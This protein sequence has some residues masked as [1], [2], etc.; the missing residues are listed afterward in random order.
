M[1]AQRYLLIVLA[2]LVARMAGAQTTGPFSPTEWPATRDAAKT[3][4]YYVTDDALAPPSGTWVPTLSILSGGDQETVD[5]SIGGFNGKKVTG[6]FMNVADTGFDEWADDEFIDILV[7]A[8]GDAGLFNAQGN[9]RNFN[10]LTGVLPDLA[11][12]VGGQVPVEA[13]NKKWN[14]ILFRIPNGLRPDGTRFVGSVPEGASAPAGGVNGGTIRFEGVPNLIVRAVAFGPEGSFGTPEDINK[15]APGDVC[16]PEP[17][18]NLVG[19]DISANT[20]SHV[21]VIN[22]GDQLVS[23]VDGVGPAG[24]KR[25]A[26]VPSG[27][28]LNFGVTENYLGKACNDPRALKVCVEFYDDPAFAGAS[29]TFGPEAYATDDKSGIAIF[30]VAQRQALQGTGTWIRRSWVVPAA[31]LRGVNAGSLTAGPR[32]ASEGGAVAVSRF[33]L[34]VLRTGDHPLANQD[35][36]ADCFADPLICT[37]VYGNFVELD[38]AKGIKNGLDVGSSGGDQTMIVDEAGPPNDRRQA[39]RPAFDDGPSTF[40][41]QYLNLSILDEA[42]GPNSQPPARLAIC[43]SYYDDPDLTGRSIRPEVYM[44]ERNGSVTLGFTPAN[45]AIVIEGTGTWRDAYWELPDVKFNGVNQGPQ[46]AARFVATGKI[47]FSRVRYAVIR[48]CGADAGK[49]LLEDCKPK[50]T[51][52]S[53]SAARASDGRVKVSW[54]AAAEGYVL[55]STVALGAAWENVADAPVVE[56]DRLAVTV[57]STG[58]R[59]FRLAKP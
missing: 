43:A 28:F 4:H 29:V 9:P 30:P 16:D 7:Q 33:Q 41:N 49:N 8:Y 52:V 11:F 19:I 44:T 26:V 58:T 45:I 17:P 57:A 5:I 48:P 21:Q 36:L 13:K 40:Q 50:V 10:F 54:L 55:Q 15:F 24:D 59:F 38:L 34:A 18:T 56:G 47:Y 25:R 20:A 6:N 23:F 12:P 46:A 32:F 2:F 35:P 3:V 14:W 31:S 53:V 51:D 22:D 39:V 42:L 27:T 37:G 1:K